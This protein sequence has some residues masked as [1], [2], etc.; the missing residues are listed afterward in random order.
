MAPPPTPPPKQRVTGTRFHWTRLSHTSSTFTTACVCVQVRA[1]VCVCVS[2]YFLAILLYL[3]FVVFWLR[4]YNRRRKRKK[5]LFFYGREV[6]RYFDLLKNQF[7]GFLSDSF[8]YFTRLFVYLLFLLMKK[9][10]ILKWRQKA[11]QKEKEKKISQHSTNMD[12]CA[13][14]FLEGRGCSHL[15]TWSPG[16]MTLSHPVGLSLR[17]TGPDRIRLDRT[18]LDRTRPDR[19]CQFNT[20][21]EDH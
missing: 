3:S 10:W 2:F 21:S 5:L 7:C 20:H 6:G 1:G 19:S 13:R 11:S 4:L 17:A 8:Q 14:H 15:V 16:H 12:F 9:G 18:G